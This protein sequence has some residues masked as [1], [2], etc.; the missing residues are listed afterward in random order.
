MLLRNTNATLK[1]VTDGTSNTILLAETAGRPFV[2]RKNGRVGDLPT[3]RVNGGGWCR[4]ASEFGL[5]GSST[6]GDSFP[7]TCAINCTNGEDYLKGGT[8]DMSIVPLT[9]GTI[10]Y[11]TNG[12][13]ETFAFHPGG[14]NML[15]GDGSVHFLSDSIDIRVYARAV[16]RKGAEVI[17]DTDLGL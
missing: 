5:Y 11:G 16:T 17:S 14:A 12:T 6:E 8:S 4:P 9:L 10:V 13:S 7:G 1:Q 15:F 2:Y 3:N